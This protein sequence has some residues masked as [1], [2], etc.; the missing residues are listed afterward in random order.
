MTIFIWFVKVGFHLF[1]RQKKSLLLSVYYFRNNHLLCKENDSQLLLYKRL[2]ST[3]ATFKPSA[4][5]LFLI[6]IILGFIL[7]QASCENRLLEI[8]LKMINFKPYEKPRV[9]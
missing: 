8:L 1:F 2:F 6:V 3:S 4:M 7:V 5:K 9:R